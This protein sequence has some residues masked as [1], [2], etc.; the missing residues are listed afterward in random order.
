MS[1]Y[2]H[3]IDPSNL[4]RR[5]LGRM[6]RLFKRYY[7]YIDSLSANPGSSASLPLLPTLDSQF[8]TVSRQAILLI[9]L[10]ISSANMGDV[11]DKQKPPPLCVS[12]R[13][14][15]HGGSRVLLSSLMP[16]VFC[17]FSLPLRQLALSLS[18]PSPHSRLPPLAPE[19][20][21]PA[22]VLTSPLSPA[23]SPHPPHCPNTSSPPSHP[24]PPES[25]SSARNAPY[26]PSSTPAPILPLSARGSRRHLL[27][28]HHSPSP[29][30]QLS[31]QHRHILR[32]PASPPTRQHQRTPTTPPFSPP[33]HDASS[34]SRTSRRNPA[35]CPVP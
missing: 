30:P 5:L 3:S 25:H 15:V 17:R 1:V 35:G 28:L 2:W 24:S 12:L 6:I 11:N 4:A 18:P 14:N 22:A 21:Q 29:P 23:P 27:R 19:S 13:L 9:L 16:A 33:R 10:R 8:L 7:Q 32:A 26:P 34:Y 20:K 31:P